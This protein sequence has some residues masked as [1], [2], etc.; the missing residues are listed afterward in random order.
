MAAFSTL[1]GKILTAG[2]N[3]YKLPRKDRS[4]FSRG[5]VLQ[6]TV[7]LTCLESMDKSESNTQTLLPAFFCFALTREK[8]EADAIKIAAALKAAAVNST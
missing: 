4:V 8:A 1:Y 2:S 3:G 5:Y 7:N 6:A